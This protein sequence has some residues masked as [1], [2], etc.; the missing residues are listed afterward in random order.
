MSDF[1]TLDNAAAE[2]AMSLMAM[3]PDR[4]GNRLAKR[5]TKKRELRKS[6]KMKKR[7]KVDEEEVEEAEEEEDY[8]GSCSRYSILLFV[9]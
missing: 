2:P 9:S 7:E 8:R 1:V 6:K 3:F 5:R 4:M